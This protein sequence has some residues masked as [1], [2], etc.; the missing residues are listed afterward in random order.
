[1]NN[2]GHRTIGSGCF[3]AIAVLIFLLAN[4]GGS[5]SRANA[6]PP[7]EETAPDDSLPINSPL[8]APD[9]ERTAE[10]L[11]GYELTKE[12]LEPFPHLTIHGPD[13]LLLGYQVDSDHAGATAEGYSG[14]VPVRVWLDTTG[15]LLGLNLRENKE[16]PAYLG[17]V[18]ESDLFERLL[19]CEPGRTDSIDA[20]TLATVS[21]IA[22]I[23]GVTGTIDRVAVELIGER[24]G[25]TEPR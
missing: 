4:C 1:M 14:P 17:L 12:W 13:D 19:G 18:T 23:K 21:S 7:A 25:Q 11:P 8:I 22:I 16:T 2:R 20:V 24:P 6:T 10:L 15:S 9:V 3:L 5:G